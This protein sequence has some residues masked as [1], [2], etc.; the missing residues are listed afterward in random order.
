MNFSLKIKA[1]YFNI[2]GKAMLTLYIPEN[3]VL[4]KV[5]ISTGAGR[6][7]L[8]NLQANLIDMQF[9]AG[10]A[11]LQNI[12]ASDNTFIKAGAGKL[13]IKDS[14][15]HN[16]DLDMGVGQFEFSGMLLGSNSLK[17][18]VG[19]SQID[20]TGSLDDYKLNIEK[21]LGDIY[22]NEDK[23]NN[24]TQLGQGDRELF[25]E[26]GIGSVRINFSE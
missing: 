3:I 2:H 17:M 13:I 26:G 10:E 22:V 15:F 1:F 24:N 23:I 11:I 12:S 14:K 18:G 5:E 20:L 8:K 21:G 19:S 6:T 9:G 16:L 25:F 7:D 4:D